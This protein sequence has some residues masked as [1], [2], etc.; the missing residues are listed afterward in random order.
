[1]SN[2]R[3]SYRKRSADE[4][5]TNLL[6]AAARGLLYISA[7]AALVCLGFL[8]YYFSIFSGGQTDVPVAQAKATMD[9]FERVLLFAM[10]GLGVSSAYLYWNEEVLSAIQ[11]LFAGAVYFAPLYVPIA[12]GQAGKETNPLSAQALGAIQ[13]GGTVFGAIAI[14]VLVADVTQRVRERIRVG[15]KADQLKYGKNIKAETIQ[16]VFMGKCWQLPYCRKFV[17]EQCPIYHAR[18][19]CWKERVGCM[20][21]ES[22]IANAMQGATIPKD[23]VAAARFIPKNNNL[24]A[25]AKAERCRHCVIY[26]ERQRHKYRLALPV[27]I[28]G[29][30]LIYIVFKAPLMTGLNGLL[31][32]MD[33]MI[34]SATFKKSSGD[35]AQ[36]VEQIGWIKEI[37]LAGIM[38]VVLSYLLKLIEWLFFKLKV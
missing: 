32:G 29:V 18:R 8:V 17:R 15:A 31:E 19:T 11:L 36:Q 28:I 2:P 27:T 13:A 9:L 10:A 12:F 38:F 3:G 33:K 4:A 37:L 25:A 1:M 14:C 7:G 34:S 16:N 26:N 30:A 35:L 20:C 21:E 6:D 23:V 24:S 5:L 22:V